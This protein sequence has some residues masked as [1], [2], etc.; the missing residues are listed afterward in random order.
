L[1]NLDI[2]ERR[3]PQDGIIKIRISNK[4]VQLRVSMLPTIFGEK[5]VMRVQFPEEFFYFKA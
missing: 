3:K 5:I 4:K 1:A 2:S